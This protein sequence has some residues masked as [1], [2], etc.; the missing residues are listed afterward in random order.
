MTVL[1]TSAAVDYLLGSGVADRVQSLFASEGQLAAPDLLVFETIA[2]LR[3]HAQRGALTAARAA[4]AIGD[5]GDLPIE[6]FPSL[7]LR[8]RA[9]ELRANLTAADALFVALAECLQEPLATRDAALAGEA[10]KHASLTVLS[11]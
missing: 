10:S 2:V 1:D 8:G 11:L 3:R 7:P 4:A 6:L 9:W 5:L